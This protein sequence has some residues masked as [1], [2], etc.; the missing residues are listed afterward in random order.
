[1]IAF[2]LKHVDEFDKSDLNQC[3]RFFFSDVRKV[4]GSKYPQSTLK[5]LAAM[6][7]YDFY[8]SPFNWNFSLSKDSEFATSR[9]FSLRAA[10]EHYDLDYGESA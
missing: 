8:H 1:M 7:Q 10:Q 5:G 4:N 6:L 2:V 3:F 9:Y